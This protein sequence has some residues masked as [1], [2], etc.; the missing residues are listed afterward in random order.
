[1]IACNARD[2]RGALQWIYAR[3]ARKAFCINQG[4][5]QRLAE[6]RQV[7][8]RHEGRTRR[9]SRAD[10]NGATGTKPE[11]EWLSVAGAKAYV[12]EDLQ[13]K[14]TFKTLQNDCIETLP[15]GPKNRFYKR[16]DIKLAALAPVADELG[17]VDYGRRKFVTE[18]ALR[19]R[20]G[21]STITP[22][23]WRMH[24]EILE[25][26]IRHEK[27]AVWKQCGMHLRLYHAWLYLLED[28]ERIELLVRTAKKQ[29]RQSEIDRHTEKLIEWLTA[30]DVAERFG[31]WRHTVVAWS[32]SCPLLDGKPIG[33]RSVLRSRPRGTRRITLYNVKDCERVKEKQAGGDPHP[34]WIALAEA[35]RLLGLPTNTLYR[36]K[37]T[38][39]CQQLNR[40]IRFVDKYGPKSAGGW[41]LQPYFPRTD[42]ELIRQQQ[43]EDWPNQLTM[44]NA[45]AAYDVPETW[46]RECFRSPQ[47]ALGNKTLEKRRLTVDLNDKLNRR[48]CVLH[49]STSDMEKLATQYHGADYVPPKLTTQTVNVTAD[50]CTVNATSVC[51]NDAGPSPI[52]EAQTSE[53]FPD[54]LPDDKNLVCL[55]VLRNEK[56]DPRRRNG[57]ELARQI[58]GE[59][60]PNNCPLAA[61]LNNTLRA[62]KTNKRG[63]RYTGP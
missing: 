62:M 29:T 12:R 38:G 17:N 40:P 31:W 20:C 21:L 57:M 33:T 51:I 15:D 9:Y 49:V 18:S 4:K 11:I 39:F 45:A 23:S 3:D 8:F 25:R 19:E 54:G 50:S 35:A 27:R 16:A 32:K 28:V 24:C 44:A 42:F 5:L 22:P 30:D 6:S 60:E 52:N 47:P 53:F 46:L 58:T 10:L 34:E 56:L 63:K 48:R 2:Q 37:E 55:A 13:S 59:T 43:I 1:M 14:I 61:S 36:W 41:K 26:P 7:R